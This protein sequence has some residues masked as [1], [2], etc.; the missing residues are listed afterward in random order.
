MRG[1]LEEVKDL[2]DIVNSGDVEKVRRFI[3]GASHLFRGANGVRHVDFVAYKP[4]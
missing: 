2:L 1:L 4:S 3:V